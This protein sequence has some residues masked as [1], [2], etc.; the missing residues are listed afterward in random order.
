MISFEILRYRVQN[1]FVK[2]THIKIVSMN[3]TY[4]KPD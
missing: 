2:L 1:V 3:G 4:L